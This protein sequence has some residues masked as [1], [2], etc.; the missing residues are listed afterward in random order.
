VFFDSKA[1]A[2]TN[3]VTNILADKKEEAPSVAEPVIEALPDID[4]AWG[5]D[6]EIDLPA[7][8]EILPSGEDLP[9]AP[10]ED[11]DIYVPPAHGADPIQ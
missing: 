3:Q 4:D 10:D 11:S 2:S 1:H 8:P 7:A 6:D 5:G 9:G